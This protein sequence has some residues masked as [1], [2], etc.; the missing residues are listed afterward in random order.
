MSG[1][2]RQRPG[3][4]QRDRLVVP[5]QPHAQRDHLAAH[6][7]RGALDRQLGCMQ[8][9]LRA[10]ARETRVDA[11]LSAEARGVEVGLEMEMVVG[12]PD[13]R[14]EAEARRMLRG[15]HGARV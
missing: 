2:G 14:R 5:V 8:D 11:H 13:V 9:D 3:R 12:R 7:G 15:R 6:L 10:R 1:A 4:A